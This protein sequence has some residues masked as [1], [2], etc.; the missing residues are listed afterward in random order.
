VV[1]ATVV[2]TLVY[3]AGIAVWEDRP[4]PLY[5]SLEVVVQSVTT[6]GYGGDAPWQTPQINALVILMQLTGIGLILTAVDVFAV[7][8]L[9]AALS[10]TAPTT[11]SNSSN[12]PSRRAVNSVGTPSRRPGSASGSE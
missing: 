5:Q 3:S 11:P 2:L 1:A 4:R 10:P 8:W 9:R 6:T 7:P 12:S